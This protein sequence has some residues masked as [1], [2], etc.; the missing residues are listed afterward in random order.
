MKLKLAEVLK[1]AYRIRNL[2]DKNK[3]KLSVITDNQTSA[4]I[5]EALFFLGF[6]L[7]NVLWINNKFLSLC[8][9][10]NSLIMRLAS[11]AKMTV[12]ASK[13]PTEYF[14]KKEQKNLQTIDI[15]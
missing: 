8:I 1:C 10:S 5:Q 3:E 14:R 9:L 13:L 6:K 12:S 2:S 4:I 15:F 11:I 7:N